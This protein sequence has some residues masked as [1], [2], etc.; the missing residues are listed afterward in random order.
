[1]ARVKD[2]I[3][4]TGLS[5]KVGNIVFRKRGHKTTAYVLSSRK[6][7]LSEKQKDA[8]LRF[9]AAVASARKALKDPVEVKR[10]EQIAVQTKK[11][12][13]YSAAIA[14]FMNGCE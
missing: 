9:A 1:M 11:E 4:T 3:V 2:N 8:Q 6:A 10:F 5:G 12:S 13:V 14:W 7:P